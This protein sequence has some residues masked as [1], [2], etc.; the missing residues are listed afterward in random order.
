MMPL[1]NGHLIQSVLNIEYGPLIGYYHEK[2]IE[3]QLEHSKGTVDECLSWLKQQVESHKHD[4]DKS[5]PL[6][7]AV[8][9]KF[10]IANTL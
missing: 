1:L 8:R 9:K 2:I 10:K 7:P 5:I 6:S 3:W 4:A